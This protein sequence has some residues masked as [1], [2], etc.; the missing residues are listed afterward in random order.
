MAKKF[1]VLAT[2]MLL[3]FLLN[4]VALASETIEGTV[5]I[6]F[7]ENRGTH[8]CKPSYFLRDVNGKRIKLLLK[9][10]DRP[11]GLPP[12]TRV[13]AV[14]DYVDNGFFRCEKIVPQMPKLMGKAEVDF[15]DTT[16]EQ[17]TV[18]LLIKFKDLDDSQIGEGTE[19]GVATKADAE[20]LY[21]NRDEPWSLDNFYRENSRDFSGDKIWFTGKCHDEWRFM[22]E[23]SA[24]Y[25]YSEGGQKLA[26]IQ[27]DLIMKDALKVYK[28]VY[29]P[30]YARL[31]IVMGGKWSYA[32]GTLG[33][34]P[35]ATDDGMVNMSVNWL[36]WR[37]IKFEKSPY[38]Y[39]EMGHGLG[40]YHI[41]GMFY[42]DDCLDIDKISNQNGMFFNEYQEYKP[43]T[44]WDNSIMG[45]GKGHFHLP[46]KSFFGWIN[47]G[48]ILEVTSDTIVNIDQRALPS[49]GIKYVKIPC[50]FRINEFFNEIQTIFYE[51]E[52]GYPVSS[53]VFEKR[54]LQ[55]KGNVILRIYTK[56]DYWGQTDA[57]AI[58]L[59]AAADDMYSVLERRDFCD[60]VG[61]NISLIGK[62]GVDADAKATV[63]IWFGCVEKPPFLYN[64]N[65]W[66]YQYRYDEFDKNTG[67]LFTAGNQNGLAC[68]KKQYKIETLSPEGWKVNLNKDSLELDPFA[69][70]ELRAYLVPPDSFDKP[71]YEI[72]VRVTDANDLSTEEIVYITILGW[73]PP[74]PTPSPA[75]SP[76]PSPTP[77]PTPSPSPT[78]TPMTVKEIQLSPENLKVKKGQQEDDEVVTLIS[79]QGK[80]VS[81][82]TV[83]AMV[84]RGKRKVSVSPP[85]ATSDQNGQAVFRIK[86]LRK[87]RSQ[88]TFS[89]QEVNKTLRVKVK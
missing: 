78:P 18:V 7:S 13:T 8:E 41:N 83:T 61:T 50:G 82:E 11:P 37:D 47:E 14:G 19:G 64:F 88:V 89:A 62:S 69:I 27:L 1:V 12:N 87:G 77:S 29:F 70:E 31:V 81:G 51:M 72:K 74:T 63:K 71:N 79:D 2:G 59:N 39:H 25:G 54:A 68:G 58:T 22:P 55:E 53:S 30:D 86:G 38:K 28:D 65:H 24:Y 52:Y 23:N 5:E 80:K 15:S 75:P 21:F 36:D 35:V 42:G 17:P 67:F 43:Y 9:G 66:Q 46:S 57:D 26:D 20:N 73:T 3:C 85:S 34:T 10:L 32:F 56:D 40:V 76:K 45:G 6:I 4:V 60:S 48:Q 49:S 84:T 16:G 44:Y 33:K